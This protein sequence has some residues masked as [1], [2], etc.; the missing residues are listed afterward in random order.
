VKVAWRME[1]DTTAATKLE[2]IPGAYF[3]SY[4]GL[5]PVFNPLS[6]S[7][8]RLTISWTGTGTLLESTNVALPLS[9]WPP[10]PGNPA[11]SYQVVP[12]TNG[13]H[14]FYRLVQ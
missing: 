14:M 8:G 1:G 10:V 11:G 13:P 7:N 12:A 3:S 9:Q 2:P 4:A 5:P 6:F